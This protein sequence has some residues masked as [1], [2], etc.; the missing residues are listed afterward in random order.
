MIA[1]KGNEQTIWN[2]GARSEKKW[3]KNP[4]KPG[5]LGPQKKSSELSSPPQSKER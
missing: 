3:A 2:G 4:S 1:M 5:E